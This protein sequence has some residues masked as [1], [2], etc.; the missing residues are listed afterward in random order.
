MAVL[1]FDIDPHA[2]T[3]WRRWLSQL[4]T[5]LIVGIV[6]FE[7]SNNME[8]SSTPCETNDTVK[9]SKIVT[10]NEHAVFTEQL[11]EYSITKCS[12]HHEYVAEEFLI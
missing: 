5:C 10:V 8:P 7:A 3:H 6:E 2:L 4:V 9:N 12:G 1:L 11:S